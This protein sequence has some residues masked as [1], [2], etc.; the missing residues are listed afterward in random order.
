LVRG[1]GSGCGTSSPRRRRGSWAVSARRM[2]RARRPPSTPTRCALPSRHALPHGARAR[3]HALPRNN[4]LPRGVRARMCAR[5]LSLCEMRARALCEM[6]RGVLPLHRHAFADS[7]WLRRGCDGGGGEQVLRG[8]A[9][10]VRHILERRIPS[11]AAGSGGASAMAGLGSGGAAHGAGHAGF[12]GAG[13]GVGVG[14]HAGA[15]GSLPVSSPEHEDCVSCMS[16]LRCPRTGGTRLLSAGLD[17]VIKVW[18]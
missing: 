15:K 14:L 2:T 16:V 12:A 11:S 10:E 6:M 17:G 3:N 5:A 4:A 13:I 9:G 1:A 7:Q 8:S 18:T